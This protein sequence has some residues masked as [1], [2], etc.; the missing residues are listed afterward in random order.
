MMTPTDRSPSKAPVNE[1][2]ATLIN[3]TT[4]MPCTSVVQDNSND[5]E[6]EDVEVQSFNIQQKWISP[7]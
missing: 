6:E 7:E 1:L 2:I 3:N 5:S 4:N